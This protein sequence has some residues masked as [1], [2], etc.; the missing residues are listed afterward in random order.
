META[1]QFALLSTMLVE[2][3]NT[4]IYTASFGQRVNVIKPSISQPEDVRFIAYV[5]DPAIHSTDSNIEYRRPV[6]LDDNKRRQ[7][8]WHKCNPH[9]LF[10]DAD[11]SLWTDA[12]FQVTTNVIKLIRIYLDNSVLCTFKHPWRNCIYKEAKTCIALRNDDPKIIQAQME[13]LHSEG[14]PANNGLAATGMMLRRNTVSTV[15]FNQLW[16]NMI[17]NGSQRDQLS[18]DYA[19][20]KLGLTYNHFPGYCYKNLLFKHC[21]HGGMK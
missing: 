20:W 7:A 21:P 10:P 18:F 1:L 16:W 9:L 4:T 8:R 12:N 6:H 2:T 13:K 11:Y 15:N 3:M 5:D 17:E 19:C 14:Y